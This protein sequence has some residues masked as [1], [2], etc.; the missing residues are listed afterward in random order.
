MFGIYLICA[1]ISYLITYSELTHG[2][3]INHIKWTHFRVIEPEGMTPVLGNSVVEA[4]MTCHKFDSCAMICEKADG[5]FQLNV[6]Q[7]T[8]NCPS[9]PEGTLLDCYAKTG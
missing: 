2:A 7:F 9:A 6:V 5:F 3:K 4:A 1:S 8:W